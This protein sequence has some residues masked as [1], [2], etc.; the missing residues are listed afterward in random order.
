MKKKEEV[1]FKSIP[2]VERGETCLS[3]WLPGS[4]F[5]R[6][7]YSAHVGGCGTGHASTLKAAKALL[8]ERA[9]DYCR[10]QIARAQLSVDHY[11]RALAHLERVGLEPIEQKRGGV[12]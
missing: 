11:R 6:N 4:F 2:G 1:V 9:K 8:L 3:I 5:G 10:R 12:Q 7:G